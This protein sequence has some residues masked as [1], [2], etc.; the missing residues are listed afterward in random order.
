MVSRELR[1]GSDSFVELAELRS[2]L[3][4]ADARLQAV[5]RQSGNAPG[6]PDPQRPG[7]RG[8]VGTDPLGDQMLT[9]GWSA[10]R[11]KL[12]SLKSRSLP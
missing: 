8:G 6:A 11:V 9:V 5:F 10:V 1:N 4:Q 3:E 12:R 7:C 2:Q